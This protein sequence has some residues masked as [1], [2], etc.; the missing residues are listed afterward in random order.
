[1]SRAYL[2][3]CTIIY[4]IEAASPFH[5]KTVERLGRLGTDPSTLLVTS[6][7]SMIECRTKP[8]KDQDSPL[9]AAYDDFFT[10]KRLLLAE[11]T[12]EVIEH[13]TALRAKHGFRTPDAIHL[14]TA[15][16]EKADVFLTGDIALQACREVPVELIGSGE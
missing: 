6:R 10:R 7:L 11:I 1:M 5:Q 3:A 15:V 2:D 12:P 14:A 16:E 8:M 9:L 13:A 4:L